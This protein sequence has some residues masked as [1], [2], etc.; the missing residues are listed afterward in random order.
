MEQIEPAAMRRFDWRLELDWL[1][2]EQ[3]LGLARETLSRQ[4]SP[5]LTDEQAHAL[6]RISPVAPGD[7]KVA[8]RQA[9]VLGLPLTVNALIETL[10]GEVSRRNTDRDGIGFLAKVS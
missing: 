3:I 4:G 7:F 8:E 5:A 9:Q 10:R 6:E 2:P 1:R